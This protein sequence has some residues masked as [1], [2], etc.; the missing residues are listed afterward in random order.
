MP[1]D[2]ARWVDRQQFS[3]RK[4]ECEK[5]AGS[6]AADENE[7]SMTVVWPDSASV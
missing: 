6:K 4:E 5:E 2:G 3:V 1:K 7:P